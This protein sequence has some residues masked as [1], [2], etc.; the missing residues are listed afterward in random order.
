MMF[1]MKKYGRAIGRAGADSLEDLEKMAKSLR[2]YTGASAIKIDIE[3]KD[4]LIETAR[5]KRYYNE[6]DDYDYPDA[7]EGD[8]AHCAEDCIYA[9]EEY[10]DDDD[11]LELE[12]GSV[13]ESVECCHWGRSTC[14][15]FPPVCGKDWLY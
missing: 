6:D 7:C 3:N 11:D 15:N 4:I 12:E 14:H 8:C 10:D 2:E 5:E 9:D 1:T 13:C